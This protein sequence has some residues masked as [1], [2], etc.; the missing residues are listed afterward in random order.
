MSIKFDQEVTWAIRFPHIITVPI[1][2]LTFQ[3]TMYNLNVDFMA[4][5][6][7]IQKPSGNILTEEFAIT[8]SR[9]RDVRH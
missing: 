9:M 4:W 5:E 3:T 8:V 6:E 1:N 7:P 2:T